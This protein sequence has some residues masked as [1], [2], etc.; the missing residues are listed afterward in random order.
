MGI[1]L[2]APDQPKTTACDHGSQDCMCP[3]SC[4]GCIDLS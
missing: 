2:V 4:R 1:S 3:P